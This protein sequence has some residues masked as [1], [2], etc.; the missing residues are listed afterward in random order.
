MRRIKKG[1]PRELGARWV[2]PLRAPGEVLKILPTGIAKLKKGKPIGQTLQTFGPSM[3]PGQYT[4]V[5]SRKA[6]RKK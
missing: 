2:N 6:R 4:G 3:L 1:P 5:Y